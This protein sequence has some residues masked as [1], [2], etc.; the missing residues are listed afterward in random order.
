MLN[1]TKTLLKV[2]KITFA[3]QHGV[4]G[5]KI[6]R[7]SSLSNETVIYKVNGILGSF[8]KYLGECN[9]NDRYTLKKLLYN[10]VYI[11]RP[12]CLTFTS[13]QDL[14]IPVENVTFKYD[15]LSNY[16]WIGFE[17]QQK[18][19]NKKD[20]KALGC[21]WRQ[22]IRPKHANYIRQHKKFKYTSDLVNFEP[23]H[24]KYR[25]KF[26]YIYSPQKLWYIKKSI[27]NENVIDRSSMTLTFAAMHRFSELE[28]YAPDILAHHFESGHNWLL[29]EFLNVSVPQFID[30]IS[31][32][33][34]GQNFQLPQRRI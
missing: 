9:N 22:D 8:C 12:Y 3:D 20:I 31:C 17:L 6:N 15:N 14:F 28:R 33:I 11:H 32:E 29:S 2:K 18:N 13:Q 30:E 4:S 7:K 34:T 21:T 16:G 5:T 23:Y 19:V 25:G 10:L 27:V 1:A 24:R 26:H